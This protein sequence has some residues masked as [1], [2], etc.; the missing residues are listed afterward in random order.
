MVKKIT[1]PYLSYELIQRKSKQFLKKHHSKNLY[2][3]PIERIVE[4][5]LKISIIGIPGLLDGLDI[6]GWLASNLREIYVDKNMYEKRPPRYNFTLAHEVGHF[7][8]H[9][10]IYRKNKIH[11]V[12]DWQDFMQSLSEKQLSWFEWQAR[13]FAGLI[14]VPSH[15]LKERCGYYIKK[16]KAVGV[17]NREIILSRLL[18]LTAKDFF[19]STSVIKKR[20]EKEKFLPNELQKTLF[21]D[22]YT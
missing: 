11:K 15:L 21:L 7:V 3:I 2:P 19:V 10:D 14:L 22:F 20:L 18:D 5:D 17:K 16:I 1:A 6:D 8:L 4:I 13:A 9:S 12:A